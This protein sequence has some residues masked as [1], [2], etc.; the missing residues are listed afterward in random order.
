MFSLFMAATSLATGTAGA[1]TI[2]S[3]SEPTILE[4]IINQITEQ[5]TTEPEDN[6]G[7]ELKICSDKIDAFFGEKNLPLAGYGD[8]FT[9]AAKKEGADC[10]I[11]YLAAAKAY[12]ESTGGKFT[13]GE[14]SSESYNAFGWGCSTI[15]KCIKFKSFEEGITTVIHNL[16]G[17]NPSTAR[18]YKDKNVTQIVNT[19]NPPSV[20]ERVYGDKN[21][22]LNK[23]L[24]TIKKIDNIN[25]E[26]NE[27]DRLASK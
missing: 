21:W 11:A 18:L 27:N 1:I 17:N 16:A 15:S 6:L 19:Y 26:N 13:P 4:M 14:G 7:K 22:Y 9:K 2:P 10:N 23:V 3:E 25:L 8:V 12:L 5:K 20:V 24:G